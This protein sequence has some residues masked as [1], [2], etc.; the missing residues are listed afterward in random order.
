MAFPFSGLPWDSQAVRAPVGQA[1]TLPANFSGEAGYSD[2][3]AT[4]RAAFTLSYIRSRVATAFGTVP[5]SGAGS[6]IAKAPEGTAA[7]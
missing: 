1:A 5:F 7:T 6:R 4:A 2:N 3:T